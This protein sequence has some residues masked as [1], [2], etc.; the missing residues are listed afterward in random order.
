MQAGDLVPGT[1]DRLFETRRFLF[2]QCKDEDSRG[3][4]RVLGEGLEEIT[5]VAEESTLL[6][7]R[8][9]KHLDDY[10]KDQQTA[11]HPGVTRDVPWVILLFAVNSSL[12]TVI[13]TGL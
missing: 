7:P 8:V 11:H 4:G 13:C 10:P 3:D 6:F 1:L 2:V 5:Q 12:P 9:L